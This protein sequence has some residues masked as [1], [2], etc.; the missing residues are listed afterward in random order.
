MHRVV[1]A[2]VVTKASIIVRKTLS[3]QIQRT[4]SPLLC[5]WTRYYLLTI[6]TLPLLDYDT[7]PTPFPVD[8]AHPRNLSTPLNLLTY[9][10]HPPLDYCPLSD[11][12]F[13]FTSTALE[14]SHHSLS[15]LS[16][17]RCWTH[18]HPR[19]GITRTTRGNLRATTR[20]KTRTKV[21]VLMPRDIPLTTLKRE[22]KEINK[23]TK[24]AK[25]GE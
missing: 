21:W 25:E 9:S 8:Q 15:S 16:I 19:I 13:T 20:T 10:L 1:Q 6:N 18:Y 3:R 4:P 5:Q 14:S 11:I 7:I 12:L 22:K 2:V 23:E 17:S 24:I